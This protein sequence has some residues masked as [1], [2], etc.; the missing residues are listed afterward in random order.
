MMISVR[1]YR[2]LY[3]LAEVVPV[4]KKKFHVFADVGVFDREENE[5]NSLV[6]EAMKFVFFFDCI[7]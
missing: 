4:T 1:C 3:G 5:C 7:A 2:G 6:P